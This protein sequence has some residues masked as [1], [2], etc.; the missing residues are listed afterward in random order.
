VPQITDPTKLFVHELS[1]ILTAERAIA[2]MLTT[3][4]STASDD[5]LADRLG[6]HVEETKRHAQNVEEVFAALG[7]R[8]TAARCPAIEGIKGELEQV[9]GEASTPDLTDLVGVGIGAR[10]E[11]YEIASYEGLI[12]MAKAMGQTKA[13]RLLENNLKD[14]KAMLRDGKAVARRLTTRVTK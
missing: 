12:A 11:H 7:E 6:Q 14:E 2:Q 1:D 13:I 5:K 10:M 9:A 4:Q 8:P 3:M